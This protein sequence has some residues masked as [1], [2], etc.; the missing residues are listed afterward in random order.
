M[1]FL[2]PIFAN[3]VPANGLYSVLN[4]GVLYT[5]SGQYCSFRSWESFVQTTG[6]TTTAGLPTLTI[7]QKNQLN[8]VGDCAPPPPI[9]PGIY[10]VGIKLIYTASG[11]YCDFPVVNPDPADPT[12]KISGAPI[13]IV[14]VLP[15]PELPIAIAELNHVGSCL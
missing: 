7:A 12:V 9:A 3:A 14:R 2:F 11:Q 8:F 5:A 15:Y 4:D 10:R 13:R 1:I 6:L